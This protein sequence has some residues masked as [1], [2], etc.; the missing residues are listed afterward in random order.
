MV[1]TTDN[2]GLEEKMFYLGSNCKPLPLEPEKINRAYYN[3]GINIYSGIM[4]MR[5]LKG[6]IEL[7]VKDNNYKD[8]AKQNFTKIQKIYENVCE[9]I[10]EITESPIANSETVDQI[11]S[12]AHTNYILIEKEF[13]RIR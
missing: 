6:M 10:S 11:K 2:M 9:T 1:K 3:K 5:S 13:E 7:G 12:W 4:E 8:V